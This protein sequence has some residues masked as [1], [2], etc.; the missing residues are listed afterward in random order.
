MEC[1]NKNHIEDS[2]LIISSLNDLLNESYKSAV[3]E[4][5]GLAKINFHLSYSLDI[6]NSEELTIVHCK[7]IMCF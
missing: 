3:I 4:S 5:I 1:E 2:S 7:F 6:Y